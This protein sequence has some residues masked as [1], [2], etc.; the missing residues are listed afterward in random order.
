M[1]TFQLISP[2][3][4]PLRG[5]FHRVGKR[6]NDQALYHQ[7]VQVLETVE[8]THE[9]HPTRENY[10]QALQKAM[11]LDVNHLWHAWLEKTQLAPNEALILLVEHLLINHPR[12][13][14]LYLYDLQC[15]MP[16]LLQEL[17]TVR[18]WLTH[19]L[20]PFAQ[21]LINDSRSPFPLV[22]PSSES[23]EKGLLVPVTDTTATASTSP[24]KRYGE[25]G[26]PA[27]A[28][29][30]APETPLARVS[31][32]DV[33]AAY[34]TLKAEGSALADRLLEDALSH[35]APEYHKPFDFYRSMLQEAH[36]RPFHYEPLA[37]LLFV[38]NLHSLSREERRQHY[39]K[40][41]AFT[42]PRHP[43]DTNYLKAEF[44]WKDDY[45][46]KAHWVSV[47]GEASELHIMPSIIDP[48]DEK[49][50]HRTVNQM[51]QA[52]PTV[53]FTA[54]LDTFTFSASSAFEISG[55]RSS[56]TGFAR[57]RLWH[58]DEETHKV[59]ERDL[60]TVHCRQDD[61][62]LQ[63]SIPSDMRLELMAATFQKCYLDIRLADNTID[64]LCP[65]SEMPLES[66]IPV[67]TNY[68][69]LE[70][71]L[72]IPGTLQLSEDMI[73]SCLTRFWW[74]NPD[75]EQALWTI[76]N[77]GLVLTQDT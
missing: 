11:P 3:R 16:E 17:P 38:L 48:S 71:Y 47:L 22:Q 52:Q 66:A 73:A 49:E 19:H 12:L 56:S 20:N 63:C 43:Y 45:A 35:L 41:F 23:M 21:W 62:T 10:W 67:W 77:N 27:S 55:N 59:V 61:R 65:M 36:L 72:A 18:T 4:S 69:P 70:H 1:F 68:R 51:A 50:V 60:G 57:L 32:T 74:L 5:Y 75:R 53:T 26:M 6:L 15:Q 54:D 76:V 39:D 40:T 37:L 30:L 58:F 8:A 46:V 31:A 7:L 24:D 64:I 25:H 44:S 28:A 2:R 29:P 33:F 13:L 34:V 14:T 9:A 42:D